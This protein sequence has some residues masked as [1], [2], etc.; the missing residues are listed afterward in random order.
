MIQLRM[1]S[2]ALAEEGDDVVLRGV[3]DPETLGALRAD[4]Y[5][6][7]V[8]SRSYIEGIAEGFRTNS[9]ADID[10]GMRGGDYDERAGTFTL[11]DP[12]YIVDGFQRVNAARLALDK[13]MR[14]VLGAALRFNTSFA[15]EKERFHVLN[16]KRKRIAPS[17]HLRNL[18]SDFPVVEMLFDLSVRDEGF[19]LHER[20]CWQQ[21]MRRGHLL[22]AL[23][24][25]RCVGEL[26]AH[27]G[28]GRS[29][30]ME[31]LV[32]AMQGTME[33]VGKAAY[34]GNVLVFFG[35]MEECWAV[36][37][38]AYKDQAPV[39]RGG[40]LAA[41]TKVLDA[42]EEFWNEKQLVVDPAVRR[43]LKAFPVTDPHVA[44]LAS[45]GAASTAI[46]FQML[47]SHL[48]AGRRTKKLV[49]RPG[50]GEVAA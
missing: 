19:P 23:T 7:E 9:V 21:N 24:L 37:R 8:E 16:A 2:A 12:V 11:K 17:I 4:S 38:V 41:L 27:F 47:V 3:I 31:Q 28:A 46:L 44:A 50:K 40:F 42:H 30:A 43:K 15:W 13:G 45:G 32:A 22:T 35:L 10:L 36:S 1:T 5:Q 48:N 49:S 14:P 29:V 6:R 33:K 34:R 18:R 39:L 25:L 26:Q 20:V